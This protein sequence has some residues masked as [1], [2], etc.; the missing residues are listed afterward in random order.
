MA[1]TKTTKTTKPRAKE[2]N[3]RA[4]VP[5]KR[6][7]RK[8]AHTHTHVPTRAG[9]GVPGALGVPKFRPAFAARQRAPR[10]ERAPSASPSA[11]AS[12]SPSPPI[13]ST[14]AVSFTLNAS[15]PAAADASDSDSFTHHPKQ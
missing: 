2:E 10:P 11:S 5:R 7:A 3:V 13:D 14:G 4:A 9:Y 8:S 12:A 15:E 1:R 6:R